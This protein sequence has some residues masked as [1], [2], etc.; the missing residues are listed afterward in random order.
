MN[1]IARTTERGSAR[2]KFLVVIAVIGVI[3]YAGYLYIPVAYQAYLLKDLMQH[4]VDVAAT[5]G[6]PASW[7]KDQLTKAGKEYGVPPDA[8]IDP[9]QSDNRVEV[10]V[11]FERPIEFPGF[12]Y[13]YNFDHTVKSTAFLTF[14]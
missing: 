4:N 12:T 1:A 11:Q 14:K 6:Y 10:R 7:V 13:Q 5:Q 2:L 3:A 9:K 8:I